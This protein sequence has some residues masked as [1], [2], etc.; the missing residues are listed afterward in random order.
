MDGKIHFLYGNMC[1]PPL[2]TFDPLY[3][4]VSKRICDWVLHFLR[5]LA[6]FVC[7]HS[8]LST[9]RNILKMEVEQSLTF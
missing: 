3:G 2:G 6:P 8:L 7:E 4:H 5:I 9:V 1:W